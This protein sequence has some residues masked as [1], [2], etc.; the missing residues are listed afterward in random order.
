M[1]LHRQEGCRGD[2]RRAS[3]LGCNEINAPAFGTGSRSG[4][5]I[6]A[7]FGSGSGTAFQASWPPCLLLR[8]KPP[9]TVG[10]RTS[11]T[12][13]AGISPVADVV[14]NWLGRLGI[15]KTGLCGLEMCRPRP[16]HASVEGAS[17]QSLAAVANDP[18][19]LTRGRFQASAVAHHDRVPVVAD[20]PGLLQCAG[21]R[22]HRRLGHAQ[23]FR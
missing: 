12:L 19:A 10:K 4:S 15:A 13:T 17:Q 6:L 1:P 2:H 16:A 21:D 9:K 5:H 20:Q 3:L 7:N 18:I 22:V 14:R 8:M 11:T 23:H